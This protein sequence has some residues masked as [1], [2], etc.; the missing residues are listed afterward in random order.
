MPHRS[1]LPALAAMALTVSSCA[2]IS[3]GATVASLM[4]TKKTIMDHVVSFAT[5]QDCST[6]AFERGEPYCRDPNA[7]PPVEPVY[8]CYRTL[9]EVTCYTTPDPYGDGAG[10]VR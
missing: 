10:P 4:A 2:A 9:G 3:G 1:L 6:I 8:H 5:E 7:P